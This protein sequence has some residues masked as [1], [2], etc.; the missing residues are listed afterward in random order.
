[1]CRRS[2][3][4][5]KQRLRELL[6]DNAV[7][8]GFSDGRGLVSDAQLLVDVA[9]MGLDRGLSHHE[10][11]G[12]L[13]VAEAVGRQA[14]YLK[15]TGAEWSEAASCGVMGSQDPSVVSGL[16]GGLARALAPLGFGPG[17]VETVRASVLIGSLPG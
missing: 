17:S 5:I 16:L 6:L 10:L 9:E 15:L 11:R 7:A 3:R 13:R 4:S 2:A 12:N 1:M 14:D 8:K